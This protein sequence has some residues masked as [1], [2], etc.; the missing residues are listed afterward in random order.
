MYLGD[1]VPGATIDFKF[2]TL[3]SS[4]APTQLAGSPAVA[5]YEG[6]S[7]TEITAGVT[8]TVDFDGRT[9]LNHVRIVGTTAGL[10]NGK[11][12]QAIVTAGTVGGTSIVGYKVAQFTIRN[13]SRNEAIYYGTVTGSATTGGFADSAIPS[14]DDNHYRGRVVIF[15][16]GNLNGQARDIIQDTNVGR[17][18]VTSTWTQAPTI[19]DPYGIY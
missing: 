12:Y 7:T 4:G 19:G 9:G 1:F 14:H 11:H 13:V 16:G 15:L 6:N 10:G 17:I 2:T 5:L 3:G 18:F 8:L